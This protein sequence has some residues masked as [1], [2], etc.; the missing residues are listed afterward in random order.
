MKIYH[1]DPNTREFLREGTARRDPLEEKENYLIPLNA[2]IMAPPVAVDKEKAVFDELTGIWSVVPDYRGQ[3]LYR[4]DTGEAIRI[5]ELNIIP[6]DTMTNLIPPVHGIW[7]NN[8]WEINLA[9]Q[10]YNLVLE[11]KASA[12]QRINYTLPDWKARRHRDQIEL[13]VTTTLTAKD[14]KAKLQICHAIR[15]AANTIEAEIQISSDAA[16]IDIVNHTAWPV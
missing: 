6:D 5:I 14:Y 1:Y 9:A 7:L 10:K 13:G 8:R 16:S 3:T 4:K 2:T 12:A 11:V 15:N